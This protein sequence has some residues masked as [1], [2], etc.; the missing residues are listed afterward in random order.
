[1]KRLIG[2][3]LALVAIGLSGA[4]VRG[5]EAPKVEVR[6]GVAYYEGEG[7]D[8]VRHR[9]DLYLP[10]G[11]KGF[12][13][14]LFIHGGAWRSGSKELYGPLGQTFARQGIG[15]AVANYR[16]SPGVQHPEHIRDVARSFAWVARHAKELGAD[17]DRL[18]VSGHSAGGHLV[19]LLALAPAYLKAEGLSAERIRGVI[20]IS[21]PYSLPGNSFGNVFGEEPAARAEAFPLNH[22]TDVETKKLPPFLLLYADQDYAGLPLS[23]RTLQAALEKHGAKVASKEITER[24]HITIIARVAQPDDPTAKQIVD[25]ILGK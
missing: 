5:Q 18:Y 24:D 16:L 21:G 22:V 2:G 25:F 23:A 9:L 11:K 1:M 3:V 10:E 4:L 13:L 12:P 8:A 20:A 6:K 7:A 17:P 15:V 19:A 14:L